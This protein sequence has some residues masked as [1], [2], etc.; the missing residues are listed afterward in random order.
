MKVTTRSRYAIRALYALAIAG[1]DKIPV[2]LKKVSE[3]ESISMKYLERIFSQLLKAGIV[4]SVR[5]IYGGYIFSKPLKEITLKD[6]VN[7]MDGPIKPVDC[8][9]EDA[10]EHAKSCSINWI[11]FELKNLID[12]FLEKI[13]FDD[14]VYKN[15]TLK[16][17][18]L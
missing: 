12:N 15:F 18:D 3:M 14:L 17:E 4:D 8:I 16:K 2:S 7:I 5:G 9:D 11:W 13:T 10:C 6:V 1:G